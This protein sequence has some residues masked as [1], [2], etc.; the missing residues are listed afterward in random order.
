V[1]RSRVRPGPRGRRRTRHDVEDLR[2]ALEG[3]CGASP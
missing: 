1:D 3:R 2:R